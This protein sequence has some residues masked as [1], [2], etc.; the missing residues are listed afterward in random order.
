MQIYDKLRFDRKCI[1]CFPICYSFTDAKCEEAVRSRMIDIMQKNPRISLSELAKI[2]GH[3]K[4]S[5]SRHYMTLK[6]KLYFR[7]SCKI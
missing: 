6:R 2:T 1:V 3:S 4:P 5:V 7:V